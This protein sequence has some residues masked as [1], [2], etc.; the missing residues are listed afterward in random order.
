MEQTKKYE[1]FQLVPQD[2]L[3]SELEGYVKK[4]SENNQNLFE[5]LNALMNKEIISL[6]LEIYEQ[7][8]KKY[9]ITKKQEIFMEPF[10]AKRIFKLTEQNLNK[11]RL[12]GIEEKFLQKL[13]PIVNKEFS[14]NNIKEVED[15]I[16]KLNP[17]NKEKGLTWGYGQIRYH[18]TEDAVKNLKSREEQEFNGRL[19][20][21]KSVFR[22]DYDSMEDFTKTL[23]GRR[24]L[25][26]QI[27]EVLKY[28]TIKKTNYLQFPQYSLSEL[29]RQ[30]EK[31]FFTLNK[32]V[33]KKF[34][35]KT[36]FEA[37]LPNVSFLTVYKNRILQH[38]NKKG[39]FELTHSDLNILKEYGENLLKVL[40]SISGIKFNNQQEFEK[41]LPAEIPI[42]DTQKQLIANH[43]Y[44]KG[45]YPPDIDSII[46]DP[47]I[48]K[49]NFKDWRNPCE[50]YYLYM[51]LFDMLSG[52]EK[53]P[54][55]NK[56]GETLKPCDIEYIPVKNEIGEVT[57]YKIR[58]Y[59]TKGGI[60]KTPKINKEYQQYYKHGQIEYSYKGQKIQ[61]EMEEY[62]LSNETYMK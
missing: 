32:I 44:I 8:K 16:N 36:E 59:D 61:P 9:G 2:K 53:K 5:F 31:I 46:N 1:I 47:E 22:Q 27:E 60:L 43:F 25:R 54:S 38:T 10:I 55:F 34:N 41:A 4:M 11:M 18:I 52:R 26:E 37:S 35:N 40:K 23:S 14:E 6:E 33:Y 62:I 30:Q 57:G 28:V 24:L 45:N 58:G 51:A 3:F 49:N 7:A 21:I 50:D 13:K 29:V 42:P 12:L 20:D 19:E 15:F 17:T 39:Y 48:A 56:P